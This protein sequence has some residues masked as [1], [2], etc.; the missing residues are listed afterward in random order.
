MGLNLKE[1]TN[2]K[3]SG[4]TVLFFFTLFIV[5]LILFQAPQVFA[6]IQSLSGQ[7]GVINTG[8]AVHFTNYES[9]VSVDTQTGVMSGYAWL[10][11]LGWVAF[12][13]EEGN[14]EG[15]VTVDLVTGALTGK[16]KVIN[17]SGYLDFTNFGSNVVVDLSS[18]VFS[19]YVWSED[20]G[21]I[22]FGNPGVTTGAAFDLTAPTITLNSLTSPTSNASPLV[23]GTTTDSLGTIA[24]VEYQVDSTTGTWL[25]CT[26]SDGSFNSSSEAF[27]CTLNMSLSDGAHTIYVRATDN[28]SNTTLAGAEVTIG[29]TVDT[30]APKKDFAQTDPITGQ[31][32]IKAF[33]PTSLN[34]LNVVGDTHMP[35]F[36]FTR[37][38]DTGVG[39]SSYTIVVD[40]QDYLSNIPYVEPPVGDN[41]DTRQD[42]E[43]VI[44]EN[45]N[46]YL[47]YH[48]YNQTSTQQEVCA[49]GKTDTHYLNTG[50]HAWSVKAYDKAGNFTQTD[51]NKFLVMTNQ[52]TYSKPNQSVWFPLSLL[53]VG[54]K[55]NLTIYSTSTPE[56][57]T[58][59][60]KPLLFSDS[61]PT[62]YGIAPVG[63]TINLTLYQDQ[64][65]EVGNTNKHQL[66]SLSTHANTSSEW[67]INLDTPLTTGN[68]YLTIQA[69]DSSDNFAILKDI[70]IKLTTSTVTS[71]SDDSEVLGDNDQE[72]TL[73][74]TDPTPTITTTPTSP[75]TIPSPSPTPKRF[76][77][78]FT[79]WCW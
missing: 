4:N 51:T 64:T 5:P 19:G 41:G 74:D 28:D 12:G 20:V 38:L 32:F 68:Y 14:T 48:L 25:S 13:T 29:V 55:T 75:P 39:L 61:T 43:S 77:I 53:Q 76:C 7:A 40:D 11:D 44:K 26:A 58:N 37:G 21:W 2:M 49:Y 30:T 79:K 46:W 78:P 63:A 47:K 50:V 9:N 70:P 22:N 56:L 18:G 16:A 6:T 24:S 73:E 60:T 17:T 65:D 52:G 31:E 36:C 45:N 8:G 35:Q 54:N 57:F 66:T 67:G 59:D 15:P 27:T 62:F 34:N 71:N 33:K 42:G 10:D 23:S 1:D 72:T 3:T 69:T